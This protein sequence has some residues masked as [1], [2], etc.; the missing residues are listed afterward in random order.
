MVLVIDNYDSFTYNL[1]QL[2]GELDYPV[3]VRR[4]DQIT[5]AEIKELAPEQIIISPGP[6]RPQE[7]GISLEL[8][9]EL[10]GEIPIL[11]ICL[12]YQAIGVAWGAEI[13]QAP[14]LVHGKTDTIIK[15]E[16]STILAGLDQFQATRYHSLV[17]AN[18]TLAPRFTVTARTKSGLMMAIEDQ[19]AQL[20]GLQFHPE[21][22]RTEAGEKMIKNFLQI[23]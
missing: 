5:V 6:G 8:V 12:G 10:T 13:I 21:S 14:E 15:E 22:I 1:V 2:I 19:E 11:G 9:K 16:E 18:D 17:L 23:N 7:A 4:N 20:Y 3:Q